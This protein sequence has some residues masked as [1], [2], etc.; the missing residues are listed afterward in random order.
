MMPS[1]QQGFAPGSGTAQAGDRHH[2]DRA[3]FYNGYNPLPY[4]QLQTVMLVQVKV[5]F[6][7]LLCVDS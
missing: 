3:A 6:E 1:G 4:S 7:S 2:T 5:H